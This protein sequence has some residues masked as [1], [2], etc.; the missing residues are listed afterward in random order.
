M[1]DQRAGFSGAI[2]DAIDE[3]DPLLEAPET[4]DLFG[5]DPD[6]GSPVGASRFSQGMGS[7][8][9]RQDKRGPGRPKGAKN[10]STKEMVA[11]ILARYRHPLLGL[12]DIASTPPDQLA[13]LILPRD[14]HG[15]VLKRTVGSGENERQVDYEISKDDIR[16]AFD[17]WK[18]C[19][20]E[21][22]EYLATKQPRQILPDEGLPPVFNVYLGTQQVAGG[23][24]IDVPLGMP[25]MPMNTAHEDAQDAEVPRDEVPQSDAPA[26]NT[27]GQEPSGS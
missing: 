11:F 25:K 8:V 19:T 1:A 9:A 17:L 6:W 18:Q 13:Q 20:F 14:E 7:P 10:V 27:T 12:A 26:A 15:N 23:P 4:V 5:D 22:T 24:I 16:W 2:R 3:A 21:L